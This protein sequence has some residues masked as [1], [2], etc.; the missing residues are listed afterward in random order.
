MKETTLPNDCGMAILGVGMEQTF[1]LLKY[2]KLELYDLISN[3]A[4]KTM[5][6]RAENLFPPNQ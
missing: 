1:E 6:C 2:V 5:R 4:A 3:W